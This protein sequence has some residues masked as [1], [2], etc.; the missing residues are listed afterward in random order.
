MKF[1]TGDRVEKL[2]GRYGGPGRIAGIASEF[3]DGH[4]LYLVA[5]R[6]EGGF[7]EFCH[8]YATANLRLLQPERNEP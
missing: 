8:V 1:S 7:G 5:H 6:I 4:V 3:D 2:G